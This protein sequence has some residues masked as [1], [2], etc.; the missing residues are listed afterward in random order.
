MDIVL[1]STSPRRVELMRAM[2]LEFRSIDPLLDEASVYSPDPRAMAMARAEA[3]ALTVAA[4]ERGSMVVAA[5][6]VVVLDGQVLDKAAH[7]G[8]VRRM[9]AQLSGKEHVVMTAVAVSFPGISDAN[10]EVDMAKV[11]FRE[12][13]DEEVDWY[14]GTGEGEGKAGG[15][16]VQGL[17]GKLVEALEGDRETVVG[18][19][20]SLLAR[21]LE[22]S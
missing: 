6:T 22:V 19:P 7:E 1:A 20:T 14:A 5:D 16:A 4:R 12:L 8:D 17:G 11:T 13:S 10:V 2:G 15:Y 18:L 3:K 21:M 9:L